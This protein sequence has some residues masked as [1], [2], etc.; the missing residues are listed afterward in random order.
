MGAIFRPAHQ[1]H[2]CVRRRCAVALASLLWRLAW[3]QRRELAI[4]RSIGF[5]KGSLAGYLFVQGSVITLV[6]F[7]LGALGA[8]GLGE[9]S[10][11]KT[12]GILDPGSLRQQ[13]HPDQFYLC[14]PHQPGR[15]VPA[16][17]VAESLNLIHALKNGIIWR[18][19]CNKQ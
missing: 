9:L 2:C 6:G 15:I 16:S 12:A 1:H 3:L 7:S 13:G 10:A 4:L 18:L 17:L 5:K 19:L 14:R 11:I 8:V